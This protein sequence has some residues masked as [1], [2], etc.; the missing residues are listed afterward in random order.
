MSGPFIFIGTHTIKA[1]KLDEARE[2]IRRLVDV[3]RDNEP[4]LLGFSVYFDEAGTTLSVVQIHPDATSM[5]V[6]M[7]VIAEHL[8]GAS[9]YLESTVSEQVYGPTTPALAAMLDEW[10]DPNAAT[11]TLPVHEAG[12]LR[13]TTGG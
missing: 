12:F 4:R 6:H 10:A 1:G 2:A 3:V 7:K 8:A 13:L 5:E 11:T 9:D